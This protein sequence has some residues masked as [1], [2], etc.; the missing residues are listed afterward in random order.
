MTYETKITDDSDYVRSILTIYRD[1]KAIED[2][3]DMGEPEDN[4]FNRDW[5]W[6]EH[7]LEKAYA[8][9]KADGDAA[10]RAALAGKEKDRA[11]ES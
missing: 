8:Y 5:D 11:E 9:G 3:S 6:V 10:L 4:S 7:A 2:H 1:G